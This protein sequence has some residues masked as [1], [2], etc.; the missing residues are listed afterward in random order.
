[1][2]ARDDGQ[3]ESPRGGE[4]AGGIDVAD[5]GVHR[6]V[7]E[8]DGGEQRRPTQQDHGEVRSAA[9]NRPLWSVGQLVARPVPT[10]RMVPVRPD[11]ITAN[12]SPATGEDQIL[13]VMARLLYRLGRF[14]FRRRRLVAGLWAVVLVGLAIGVV[15][16]GGR[17]V[18]TFSIPGT[19][20]Q[21]ALDALHR[22]L[23][24]A[25]GA[26]LNVVVVSP[27]GLTL[28]DATM[29]TEVAA[30][31][32]KAA[33]L[34]DVVAVSDPYQ[35]AEIDPT[36][37]IGLIGVSYDKGED[38]LGRADLDAFD[39]LAAGG[40][41]ERLQ[42]VPGG[43]TGGAPQVGATDVIGV[44]IAAVV[45]VV[46]LGSLVAA[47]MTLLTA[48]A[49]VLA[50]MC[51]LFLVTA[52]VD[53]SSTAP[54]LA[55]MLGLA[56]G[57][58]YALFLSSRHRAQLA[59]GMD[60]E[61]SVGRAT[62][63][64]GSAVLFAGATVVVA[65][66]GLSIVGVPFLTAM[67]LA[68]A[69]TVLTAVLVALT[70][71]PAMLGFVGRR[72]LPGHLRQGTPAHRAGGAGLGFRW[73]RL[74]TRFRV[75]VIVVLILV[76]GLLS[77]PVRYLR[78]ALPDNGSAPAGSHQRVA[79]DLIAQ[80]FGAGA[81]GPLLIVVS[82]SRGDAVSALTAQVTTAVQTLTDVAAVQPGA[83]NAAGTTRLVVV[84]PAS[85]PTTEATVDLVRDIRAKVGPL[86]GT[87]AVTG[88]T[89]IGVDVSNK[90]SAALPEYLLVVIGLSFLLL[91]LAFRS[92]LVPL[93][94]AA[95]FLLTVGATFGIVVGVFQRGWGSS[96]FGV[97]RPGP[98]VSFLPI[99]MLGVLFGLAMDYE[100]FIVSRVRE[101]FVHGG[102]PAE[103]TVAG[104]GH[105]ARVVTA[106]ALI[107]SA[108]FGGFVLVDDPT[109]KTIGFGLAVG[110]LIDA[111]VVRMT[112]VP[113][114]LTLLG[115]AA[116]AF[117]RWLDKITPRVDIE[118]EGLRDRPAAH[119]AVVS[120]GL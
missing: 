58:D 75:P 57:I 97:D 33:A 1:L 96:L 67:G 8:D 78:L 48:L 109:I 81:N 116:W 108:V 91:L 101:E 3:P 7:A 71:L 115:G 60:A 41:P 70:L 5:P 65:L 40:D 113:A 30:T 15:L 106:A 25:S 102:D 53:V 77:L 10:G 56:V 28:S 79:Y 72:V 59:A 11:R 76:L 74:V 45:L 85:G 105:G 64:A 103:A 87:I 47:G 88:S 12:R 19:E 120:S 73:A 111:F 37:R 29:K 43:V 80:A 16:Y 49:G 4:R 61:E 98:L 27:S 99:I 46:T 62:G 39:A 89:A 9:H 68:A 2:L 42:V 36:G 92:I 110:V 112:L 117:P 93:K 118:G 82:G 17:T 21:Q 100:V 13:T 55:L 69:G 66:A 95:G 114:V 35:S 20:S 18:D 83:V 44:G 51:G 52:V 26:T 38:S 104:V 14:A 23:P 86:A 54:I 31:I 119:R 107:M 6:A 34:P 90:L 84:V 32:K 63:T 24:A 94:A 22:E 50:G